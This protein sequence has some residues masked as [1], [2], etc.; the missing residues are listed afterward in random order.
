MPVENKAY[1]DE[2]LK[3]GK[4]V[5]NDATE[6]LLWTLVNET[7]ARFPECDGWIVR[8]GETYTYDTPYHTVE[9]DI[10]VFDQQIA[11]SG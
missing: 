7:F 10:F 9:F 6:S 4:I 11:A 2:I 8:T 1:E 3:D 5:W